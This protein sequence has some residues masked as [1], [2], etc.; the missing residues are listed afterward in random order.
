MVTG[1][2]IVEQ[3]FE[4]GYGYRQHVSHLVVCSGHSFQ[5]FSVSGQLSLQNS[6]IFGHCSEVATAAKNQLTV[7]STCFIRQ[8]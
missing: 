7:L 5:L 4:S 8:G 2:Y 1:T 6:R 3:V